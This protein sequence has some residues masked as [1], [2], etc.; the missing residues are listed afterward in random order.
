MQ[1]SVILCTHNPRADYLRRTL[2][3]LRAQSLALHEWELIIV[4]NASRTPLAGTL[5]LKWHPLGEVG[6][7]DEVGL[8]AARLRGIAT[9][10]AE[11][12]VWV[13][14]DNILAPNYL[15]LAAELGRTWPQLGVWGCGHFE[16]EWE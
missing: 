9:A 10:R 5:D 1:L 6:R 13:D 2:E 4:D 8:T 12:L 7:E 11:T 3:G 15:E 14:D 16:P